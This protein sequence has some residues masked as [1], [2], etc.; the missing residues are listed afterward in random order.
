MGSYPNPGSSHLKAEFRTGEMRE[1]TPRQSKSLSNELQLTSINW[2]QGNHWLKIPSRHHCPPKTVRQW[3]KL[4]AGQESWE[5]NQWV[6]YGS[7]LETRKERAAGLRDSVMCRKFLM[8][9]GEQKGMYEEP[10]IWQ[11]SHKAKSN[12]L[13]FGKM[14]VSL[15]STKCPLSYHAQITN[16]SEVKFLIPDAKY[17]KPMMN[18]I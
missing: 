17:W 9:T 12:L 16:V 5:N 18:W 4:R 1:F 13:Q 3:L 8:S 10:K 11:Q 7:S 2:G 6:P 15:K 14:V